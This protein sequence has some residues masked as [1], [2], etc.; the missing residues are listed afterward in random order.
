MASVR[1]IE[2]L[3]MTYLAIA[4]YVLGYG[5]SVDTMR[6]LGHPM[7]K[8]DHAMAILWP[9]CVVVYGVYR[10]VGGKRVGMF[11]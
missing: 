1:R 10:M 9:V 5:L 6:T 7:D 4:L 2:A 11:S 3:A 8:T